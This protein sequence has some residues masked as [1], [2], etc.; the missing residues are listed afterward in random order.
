MTNTLTSALITP[1]TNRYATS[2][3]QLLRTSI[4]TLNKGGL[5]TIKVYYYTECNPIDY[6]T[7]DISLTDQIKISVTDRSACTPGLNSAT[8]TVNSGFSIDTTATPNEVV[9]IIASSDLVITWS[10]GNNSECDFTTSW[11]INSSS[12]VPSGVT[13]TQGSTGHRAHTTSKY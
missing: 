10:G 13:H 7:L 12:T 9:Y 11:T 6:T 4:T 2:G 1:Y 8:P 3:N 5:Y